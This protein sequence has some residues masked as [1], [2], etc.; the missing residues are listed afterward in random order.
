GYAIGGLSV[1]ETAGVMYDI[2]EVCDEE[3]PRNK[4]RY[5]MGV[6]PPESACKSGLQTTAG[7]P[8]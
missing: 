8:G 4:P 7:S 5:L 3:L 1:G 2:V 6:G